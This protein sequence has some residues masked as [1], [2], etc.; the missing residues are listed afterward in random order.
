MKAS[1]RWI[2]A[3]GCAALLLIG[4]GIER[5]AAS[6]NKPVK[7]FIAVDTEGPSG[8]AEWWAHDPQSPLY[9]ERRQLLMGDVNAAVEGCLEAGATEVIVSDDGKNGINTIPEMIN[10]AAKL[11]YGRGFGSGVT[12]PLLDGMDES[13]AGVIF[14]CFHSKE[15]TPNG[16]LAHT[17][18]RTPR[19]YWYNGKESG[20]MTMY[21]IVAGH[22]K[23][24]VIMVTGCEATCQEAR[25]LLGDDV[26]TVGVKKGL[27]HFRAV[28][29]APSKARM[30]IRA[31]AREAVKRAGTIKPYRFELPIKVRLQF[32]NKEFADEHEKSRKSRD[33]NWPGRRVD[34]R[35]FE[36]IISSPLDPNFIL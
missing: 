30:M 14:L 32:P 17:L 24:P 9:Q 6:A 4:F 3:V 35:T 18:S 12:P 7:I 16:V 28:L 13:F 21:A 8:I 20:E 36:A 1:P 2:L 19:H 10:P 15:G 25:E 11:I 5:Q 23:V 31:G 27:N 22:H 34:E 33:S 26:V 29:I